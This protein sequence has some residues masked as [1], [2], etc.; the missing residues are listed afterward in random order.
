MKK[1]LLIFMSLVSV[2]SFAHPGMPK[3]TEKEKWDA[4]NYGSGATLGT[5]ICLREMSRS[6]SSRVKMAAVVGSVAAYTG[7]LVFGH[8]TSGQ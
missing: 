8:R 3:M 4:F 6:G 2:A 1:T 5:A 7:L